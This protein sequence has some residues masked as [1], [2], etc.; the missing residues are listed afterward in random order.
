M[1][2]RTGITGDFTTSAGFV[3]TNAAGVM[4]SCTI[5]VGGNLSLTGQ[6][7]T[8]LRLLATSGWTL[9]VTGTATATYVEVEYSDASGGTEID[10][11]SNCIDGENNSNWNFIS[12]ISNLRLGDDVIGWEPGIQLLP[13]KNVKILI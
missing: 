2:I 3:T 5:V 9:T 7:G 13:D 1:I 11:T 8:L 12:A 4:N 10:A 6:S